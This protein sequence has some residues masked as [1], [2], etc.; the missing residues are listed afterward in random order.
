M[1]HSLKVRL[2]LF[3]IIVVLLYIFAEYMVQQGAVLKKFEELERDLAFRDLSRCVKA[4][5]REC[6][7]LK[8][9]T[10]DWSLWDDTYEFVETIDPV[11]LQAIYTGRFM[12]KI[13]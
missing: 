6:E 2:V 1:F 3:L 7:H 4:I 8:M 11:I 13:V 10:N 9:F 5:E 12:F